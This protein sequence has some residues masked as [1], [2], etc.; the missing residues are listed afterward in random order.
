MKFIKIKDKTTYKIKS[1]NVDDNN[2][3][4]DLF[5][6]EKLKIT[7]EKVCYCGNGNFMLKVDNDYRYII[8]ELTEELIAYFNYTYEIVLLNYTALEN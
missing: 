6:G 5:D 8:S 4:I 2:I 1:L 7:I 3:E